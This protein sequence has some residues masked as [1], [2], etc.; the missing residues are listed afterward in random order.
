M[1]R[2]IIGHKAVVINQQRSTTLRR[3]STKLKKACLLFKT[4]PLQ[5][6]LHPLSRMHLICSSNVK[7]LLIAVNSIT[8]ISSILLLQ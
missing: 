1:I 2:L 6:S 7:T 3:V 5:I 8:L 4:Q